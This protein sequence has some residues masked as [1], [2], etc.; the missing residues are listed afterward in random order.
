MTQSGPTTF[1]PLAVTQQTLNTPLSSLLAERIHRHGPISF[2]EWMDICLYHPGQG[3][4]RRGKPTVGRDGDFLTSPEVHPLFGA[5]IGHVAIDLWRQRGRPETFSFA[6]VGP[7]TG[8]LAESLLRYL[9]S[10]AP[11]LAAATHYTLI[12]PDATAAQQLLERLGPIQQNHLTHHADLIESETGLYDLIVAN[13][14]L[15]ALPVHRLKRQEGLWRELL[16]DHSP[17]V[18]FHEVS[19]E[20]STPNLLESLTEVSPTE[21]QIIEVAPARTSVVTSLAQSVGSAGLLLLFD[22]GYARS[23]LYAPWRRDGTLMTFRHHTPGDDPFVLPGQQDITA[24]VDIDQVVGAA[25]EAGLTPLS[26]LN[27]A[28]W[29]HNLG[30]AVLPAVADAGTDTNSYLTARRAIET[31]TD[32]A[33]LGRIAV[34]GFTRGSIGPLPGWTST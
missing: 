3:Y 9:H 19:A 28:E 29:L 7:G 2:A 26:P 20:V 11:E 32:P 10:A 34:M 24:H 18:G 21:G 1:D 17:A 25:Q 31:L 30:A 16:V 14:L 15:D 22:Y 27:Q 23:R 4:Y 8:A 5:A 13:E 33:G 6:E 12:E